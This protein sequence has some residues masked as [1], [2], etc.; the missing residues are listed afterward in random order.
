MPSSPGCREDCPPA[1]SRLAHLQAHDG[2]G[3]GFVAI[4]AALTGSGLWLASTGGWLA[5][6]AGEGLLA[7]GLVQW[8]VLLHEAGHGSLFRTRRLNVLTG[9]VA[10]FFSLLPFPVWRYVHNLHHK[11]TG[12]QDLDPTT[13]AL[14]PRSLGR[15]ERLVANVCWRWWIPLFAT[16]YRVNNFWN[17]P[18]LLRLVS[19]SARR[20][21]LL[22]SLIASLIAYL[23]IAAVVGLAKLAWLTAPA[24]LLAFV[25]EEILLVSQHTHLPMKLSGGRTVSPFPA[26]A[27]Q[28]FTRS[29]RL[30]RAASWFLLHFD[31]HELHHMYPAVPGY[32]LGLVPH[33]PAN[34]VSWW[35][36]IPAARAVPGEVLLFQNR[37]ESGLEL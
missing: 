33:A 37:N 13:A 15:G 7:L 16:L 36:W 18:R 23:T 30:P 9:F 22:A 12:W 4:A 32:R 14:V 28:P 5:W 6:A 11:W 8:F 10:G 19:P 24:M 27:Q 2:V 17:A 1:P 35:R 34:E 21:R 20:W 26:M 25:I 31:A 29:L 3:G